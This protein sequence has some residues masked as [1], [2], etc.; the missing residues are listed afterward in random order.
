[1]LAGMLRLALLSALAITA[2]ACH[3]GS[4][5]QTDAA[6]PDGGP[7]PD[8]GMLPATPPDVPPPPPAGAVKVACANADG[9]AASIQ[10]A[11]DQANAAVLS[12]T[13]KLGS[14]TLSMAANAYLGGSATL[15]YT[16]SGFAVSSNTNGGTV[17]SLT[18]NG[19]GIQLPAGDQNGW[20][21]VFLTIQNVTSGTDAIY[22]ETLKGAATKIAHNTIKNIWP[23]G[24]P[25]LP[26]GM[27]ATQCDQDC[28]SGN[29]IFFH[30]GIDNTL[31]DDNRLDEIGYDGIKGFW[32]G[33]MGNTNPY[34]G[35]NV[36]ISNNVI[37]HYHRIGIEVQ[38]AGQGNCP[39][40]CNYNIVPTDGTIAKN[41]FVYLPALTNNVFAFSL[42]FGGTNAK[43]VN[44]TGNND[45]ATCY[46][47]AGIG[48]ENS[49]DGGLLQGNVIGS[50]TQSCAQVGWADFAAS[51]YTMSGVVDNFT[52]NI[53]CGPGAAAQASV[54][55]GQDPD[56]AATLMESA[57][58]VDR[59][60][61]GAR[62][63]S[64]RA[65]WRSPTRA[66]R[67]LSPRAV[68]ARSTSRW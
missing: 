60:L 52:N 17:T 9:D 8:G 27:T 19:G 32:D 43:I 21:L 2:G 53:F 1:M 37:T 40:G 3:S 33:F 24:Y 25:N 39:G 64:R 42:M 47:R 13:C 41:N 14:T 22:I 38:A 28:L 51:G 35:H 30:N 36:V 44:N 56:D 61:S 55:N 18:F 23:G 7:S 46:V 54:M 58:S 67:S 57:G 31:I 62:A 66:R 49:L 65:T 50:I 29:G 48:M 11:L 12:G 34:L 26:S 63:T 16:G 45:V 59:Q 20:S 5:R 10:S 68:R 4:S 6:I 15:T